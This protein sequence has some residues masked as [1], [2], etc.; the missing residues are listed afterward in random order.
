[1]YNATFVQLIFRILEHPKKNHRGRARPD[2]ATTKCTKITH[3]WG[4]CFAL[5]LLLALL[6][7]DVRLARSAWMRCWGAD[8]LADITCS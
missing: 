6:H 5:H 7:Y 8:S 3:K 2:A 4:P 1:M